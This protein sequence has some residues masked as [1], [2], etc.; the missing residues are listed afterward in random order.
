MALSLASLLFVLAAPPPPPVLPDRFPDKLDGYD[1]ASLYGAWSYSVPRAKGDLTRAAL[2]KAPALEGYQAQGRL[3]EMQGIDYDLGPD[4]Y[5]DVYRLCPQ[6]VAKDRTE[7]ITVLRYAVIPPTAWGDG[8]LRQWMERNFDPIKLVRQ[9][10]AFKISPTALYDPTARAVLAIFADP[11]P[12]LKRLLEVRQVDSRTCPLLAN[13][14]EKLEGRTV[15]LTLDLRGTGASDAYPPP[16]NPHAYSWSYKWSF[17]NDGFAGLSGEGRGSL[18]GQLA[19]PLREA[20]T[21]CGI[22][23]PESV[24]SAG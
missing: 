20:A 17:T 16:V 13:A 7:C 11:R 8:P 10:K 6:D 15:A 18:A 21:A 3:L 9:L 23:R 12:E 14:T 4:T 1:I 5:S 24:V 22:D 19:E 2:D